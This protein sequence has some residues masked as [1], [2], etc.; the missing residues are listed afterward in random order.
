MIW[1]DWVFFIGAWIFTI[2]LIPTIRGKQKPELST[3]L[4]TTI[5]VF[6]FIFCFAT[7]G[8]WLSVIA[9]TAVGIAWGIL[10]YQR[11]KQAKS[12]M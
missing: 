7:L 3:S 5:I 12:K 11:W 8:L 4:T 1:Q 2:S 9:N 10:A 6:I